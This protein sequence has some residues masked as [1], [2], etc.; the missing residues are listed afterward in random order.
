[1]RA[2]RR[3]KYAN[4]ANGTF[5][6]LYIH[7]RITKSKSICHVYIWEARKGVENPWSLSDPT[8]TF[9]V[10][11]LSPLDNRIASLFLSSSHSP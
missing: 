5:E 9:T 10:L 3:I 4:R 2:S 7:I 11:S 8:G 1:M 6:L